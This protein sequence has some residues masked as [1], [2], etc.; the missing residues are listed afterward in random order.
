[1]SE[2]PLRDEALEPER[3]ELDEALPYRF[4]LGRRGFLQL[5]GGIVV[6]VAARDIAGQESGRGGSGTQADELAAWL[7]VGEDGVVTVFTGKVEVGQNARTSLAQAVGDELRTPLEKIRLVMGD[8][9]LTPYDMGT[10]GSRSTPYMAPQ[11]RKAAAVARALLQELAG[12]EWSVPA[13]DVTVGDGKVTHEPSCRTLGFGSLTHGRKL[14]RTLAGDVPLTPPERWT[15][16]GRPASKVNAREIVTGRHRYPSDLSPGAFEPSGLLYGRVLRPPAVGATLASMAPIDPQDLRGVVLVSDGDFVG[17]AA[18]RT[19]DADRALAVLRPKW[20]E[21]EQPEG[22][23]LFDELRK[24]PDGPSRGRRSEPHV[25]GSVDEALPKA[26]HRLETTYTVAY[27]AHVPLEPR[28]AIAQWKDGRLTVWTGTQ[29]PFGVKAELVEAFRLPEDAVR[30]IVPDTGSGYGGKHSGECAIEAARLA[31]TAGRPVKLVWTREEEFRF[32]YF[33][34]AGVIDVR[35]GTSASGRLLAWEMHNYNSGGSAI[36]TLYEVPNQRI[37][38]HPGR[39]PLRQ[40]SYRGLAATANHFAR[41]SHMDELA[42]SLGLDPLDFRLRNLEDPRFR[43]VLEA[44]A[45][46]FGW[47]K[48]K[49]APGHGHGIAAGFEKGSYVATCAEVRVDPKGGVRVER[50]VAA[51]ECGAVVNPLHLEN[52]VLGSLVMGL[53][54]AL[55]EAVEFD[56]GKV[57]NPRLSRYRVPRFSDTPEVEVVLLDRKDLPSAGA[58]ETPIVAVA[59]ALAGAIFAATG[60]R[61]RAMPLAPNGLPKASPRATARSRT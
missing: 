47:A 52:Q 22:R 38:F 23:T 33:R 26:A 27:I 51:F 19:S 57:L 60:K 25:T 21:T 12:A 29:R 53:G 58:G 56:R 45:E 2:R 35:S 8:T 43:A 41:E 1:V 14:V 31:R 46:R 11:L 61:L 18:A 48:A 6:L 10:F 44:A 7:Q 30:V 28:A 15:V 17:V 40:G 37:E 5:A 42:A 32:A 49:S 24:P 50:L 3:Y 55:F 16:A 20:T 54:G 34:P 39:S 4:A 13:A 9:D 59:P 36:R